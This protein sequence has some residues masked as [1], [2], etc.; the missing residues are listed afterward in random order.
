MAV[1]RCNY[2]ARR[3]G[4]HKLQ[5]V[6][7]AKRL[8]PDLVIVLG[9][10]LTRFRNASKLLHRFLRQFS[11]NGRVERLGFDEVWLDVT[12]QVEY[13]VNLLNPNDLTNAYFCLSKDDPTHGFA[14]D[15]TRFAGNTYPA[16]GELSNATNHDSLRLRLLLGSHLARH[17]RA[18]LENQKG[19]TATAG[20]STNKIL[21]KLVGNV[22]KPNGQTTLLPPYDTNA[23]NFID[24]H[25]IGKLP[26]IGFKLAQRLRG[27]VLQRAAAVSDGLV[28]GGTQERVTAVD[29]RKHVGVS[30]DSLERILAGPG[31]PH[32][33]GA[34]VWGLLHGVDDSEVG[35]VRDVPRQISIEDSYMRLDTLDEVVKELRML[36]V[37][38]LKRMHLDLLED[39]EGD[40][41]AE[42]MPNAVGAEMRSPS[43]LPSGAEAL[44]GTSASVRSRAPQPAKQR[45]IAHPR[46]IRLSTR[47]RPPVDPATNTRP[48]AFGRISRSALLP[49]FVFSLTA[50]VD[51]LGE[52][53]VQE[54]LLPLFRRLHPEKSGWNLS[55]VNVAV[56]NLAD[57]AGDARTSSGRDIGAMFKTQN[58]VLSQW[59]VT[60]GAVA[61]DPSGD[62]VTIGEAEGGGHGFVP[63]AAA[64]CHEA[65]V[66]RNP[67]TKC[68]APRSP[69]PSHERS[70]IDRS[71]AAVDA[72]RVGSEDLLMAGVSSQDSREGE[73]SWADQ[74]ERSA[75]WDEDEDEG[76]MHSSCDFCGAL[77]PAFAMAAH[78]RFHA[79][80][81]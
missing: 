20:I 52:R 16:S 6:K 72:R 10:D 21:S 51:S 69:L 58:R 11:W 64:S 74:A 39:E 14:F 68:V 37:S 76:G 55:L 28:F 9:E 7:E 23:T 8:C 70:V 33:I 73:E 59:R 41:K 40:D 47:P 63:E 24:D 34:K 50:P 77:M 62:H 15:A 3:R 31:S 79:L 27:F 18:E 53:L 45:W 26:G 60:E 78:A 46:T 71:G 25:D 30:A 42:Q 38:L 29:V 13:N 1:C 2:E 35:Q 17:L 32:G 66:S 44:A 75:C 54:A 4:L 5:L 67:G 80:E 43:L 65:D 49:S 56:T 57:S 48:R 81:D 22:K 12:D 19:Y 61:P 36:A